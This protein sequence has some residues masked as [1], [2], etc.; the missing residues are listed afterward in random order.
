M[1]FNAEKVDGGWIVFSD[2]N[3]KNPL[4]SRTRVIVKDNE[5]VKHFKEFVE[6]SKAQPEQLN[7]G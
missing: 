2:S 7:E 6:S 4:R 1:E 5:L 3:D